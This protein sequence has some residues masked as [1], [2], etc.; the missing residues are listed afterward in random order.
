V[1]ESRSHALTP[2]AIFL[3]LALWTVAIALVWMFV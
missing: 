1:E 2:L 3:G